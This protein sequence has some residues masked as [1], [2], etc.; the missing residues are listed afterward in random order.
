[1]EEL[2][3]WYTLNE[4]ME[5]FLYGDKGIIT[6]AFADE[7]LNTYLL[8]TDKVIELLKELKELEMIQVGLTENQKKQLNIL[9]DRFLEIDNGKNNV[10]EMYKE[11]KRIYEN[12][13]EY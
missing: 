12:I 4:K 6:T 10:N 8:D 13:E 9:K 11:I 1:M 7:N 3:K 2:T 5:E